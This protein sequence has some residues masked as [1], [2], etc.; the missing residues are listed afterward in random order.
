MCNIVLRFEEVPAFVW[1]EEVA[2]IADSFPEIIICSRSDPP[3]VGFEFCERHLDR[4]EIRRISRQE[5]EP[6]AAFGERVSGALAFVRIEIVEDH[7]IAFVQNWR[8]LR[9]D[10]SV[11]GGAIHSAVDDPRRNKAIAPKP[12]DKSLRMPFAK[13]RLPLQAFTARRASA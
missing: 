3:E 6:C 7:D 2:Y 1:G 11:E 4:I 8:Q 9:F 12:R 13:W 10:I 5:Q